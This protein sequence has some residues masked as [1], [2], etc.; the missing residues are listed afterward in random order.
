VP[1]TIA[2]FPELDHLTPDQ[3]T[4]LLRNIPRWTYAVI[5]ARSLILG[6]MP[7]ALVVAAWWH[8]LGPDRALLCLGLA[9][10]IAT[11][12]YRLQL[13]EVRVIMRNEIA[14]SFRGQ[15]PPF[16]FHCGYDLR[17]SAETRCPECGRDARV[18]ATP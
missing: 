12:C 13:R 2:Q 1:W 3:R 10:V 16:C 9:P 4:T 15:R 17:A 8:G 6:V 5:V 7:V 14:Q 11:A 18:A